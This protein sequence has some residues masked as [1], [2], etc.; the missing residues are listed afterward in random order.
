MPKSPRATRTPLILL[1]T[2]HLT[3]ELPVW[4]VAPPRPPGLDDITG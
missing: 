2:E 3:P 4:V 1:G